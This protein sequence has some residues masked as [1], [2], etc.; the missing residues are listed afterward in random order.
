MSSSDDEDVADA[1]GYEEWSD[2]GEE[3]RAQSLFS[4]DLFPD[5]SAAIA[6]DEA[7][8]N[9]DLAKFR[10]EVSSSCGRQGHVLVAAAVE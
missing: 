2:D 4:A 1:G 5:S 9:F 6:Y 8:H 7:N 10:L 3:E